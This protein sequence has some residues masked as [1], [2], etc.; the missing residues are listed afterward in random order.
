MFGHVLF[1]VIIIEQTNTRTCNSTDIRLPQT[2]GS[3]NTV[4][5]PNNIKRVIEAEQEIN[6]PEGKKQD[7][8][9]EKN[10]LESI[11]QGI[12]TPR[13]PPQKTDFQDIQRTQQGRGYDLVRDPNVIK[14]EETRNPPRNQERLIQREFVRERKVLQQREDRLIKGEDKKMQFWVKK[15]RE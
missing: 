5:T 13:L 14:E 15:I 1:S 2:I 3:S 10:F 8:S 7:E 4:T 12:T 9:E 11:T 6:I